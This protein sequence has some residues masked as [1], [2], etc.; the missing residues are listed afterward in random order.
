MTHCVFLLNRARTQDV[1][2]GS[3][4]DAP[5]T[6]SDLARGTIESTTMPANLTQ[7]Y[8]KA[9]TAYRQAATLAEELEC[10]Q[11]M[12]RELPKHKGTDKLQAEL[13]QKISKTKKEL[14]QAPK[15]KRA[16]FRIPR[17]GA[18]RVVVIGAPN[19][20]KSQLLCAMTRARPEVAPYP[21]TTREPIPGMMPWQDVMVQMIDTPPITPYVLDSDTLSLI[22]GADLVLLLADLG[23]DDGIQQV[24][25]VVDRTD[26]TRTRLAP[27]T[28]ID[29]NDIGLTFTKTLLI[30]NKI[31]AAEAADRLEL[32]HEFCEFSFTEYVVSA[33]R[34]TGL[35]SLR[36]AVFRALDVVRVYTKMPNQKQPDYSRP[37]TIHQG[38]TLLDVAELIHKDFVRNLKNA[39]VWGSHV[40]DGTVVKGD[41]VVHDQDVVELH[42]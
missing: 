6:A 10:L 33:H 3:I 18:G 40:H 12:L 1:G 31:D 30:P 14:Q 26:Q 32:L 42:I 2:A 29:Q 5:V 13:K 36:E 34:G 7:Q 4:F 19:V 21:F 24:Q 38:G 27:E 11:L 16:G 37:Y 41:Y 25:D 35:E 20:G 17:Q 15:A 8:L 9:E 22:R 39:R 23:S 28:Y